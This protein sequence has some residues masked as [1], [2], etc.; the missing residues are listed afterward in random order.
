MGN[1]KAVN[2]E[3]TNVWFNELKQDYIFDISSDINLLEKTKIIKN[4]ILLSLNTAQ[5]LANLS[6]DKEIFDTTAS[7]MSPQNQTT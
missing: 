3:I 5:K 6:K 4:N 2:L 1:Y 7:I